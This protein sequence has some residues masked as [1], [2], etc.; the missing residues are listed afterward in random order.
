MYVV[1]VCQL[2]DKKLLITNISFSFSRMFF[3]RPLFSKSNNKELFGKKD[4]I[5]NISHALMK[6]GSVNIQI[7]FFVFLSLIFFCLD[8]LVCPFFHLLFV[9]PTTRPSLSLSHSSLFSKYV[10][11]FVFIF[12]IFYTAK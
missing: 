11:L 5:I 1:F 4:T 8:V 12:E 6:E 7:V 9:Y 2:L 3:E 10:Y